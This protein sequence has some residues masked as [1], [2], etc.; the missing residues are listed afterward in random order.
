M[1]DLDTVLAAPARGHP[2]DDHGDPPLAGSELA[3]VIHTSGSTGR[4]LGVEV[5]RASLSNLLAAIPRQV[6]ISAGDVLLAVTTVAFDIAALELL[7]PLMVGATVVIA[8]EATVGDG[9]RLSQALRGAGITAMQ[10]TP[11]TWQMLIDAG[12]T[13]DRRLKVLVGGERLPQPLANALVAQCGGVWNLYGPTETTIWSTCARIVS[14]G[15]SDPDRPGRS[16]TPP[17]AWSIKTSTRSRR[18]ARVS[19]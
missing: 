16:P 14:R 13:G 5:R 6:P 7:L 1:I 17:A 15:R 12:W 19:S 9:R 11:A 18:A 8:D 2:V 4:P 3:Y 10:A